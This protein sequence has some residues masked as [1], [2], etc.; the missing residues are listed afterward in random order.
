MSMGQSSSGGVTK[1]QREGAILGVFFSID[2]SLYSIVFGAHT[3]T[4]E[5]LEML[6]GLM[7]QVG[8]R[9]HVLDRGPDSPRRRGNFRGLSWP[10]K[11]INNL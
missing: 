1:S 9:Y 8:P 3:K 5:P 4:A 11:S 2:N 7:T 6:F 10:F